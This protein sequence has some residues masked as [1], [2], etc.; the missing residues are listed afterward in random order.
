MNCPRCGAEVPQRFC[1]R[2]G[3]EVAAEPAPR[4]LV[5]C[6]SCG[7]AFSGSFCPYCGA[8]ARP[9]VPAVT[10]C[11]HCGTLFQG[12]YCP[13]CG[14]AAA[15]YPPY[16]EVS[17]HDSMRKMIHVLGSFVWIGVLIVFLLLLVVI[18]GY[19]FWGMSEVIPGIMDQGCPDCTVT[20]FVLVPFPLGLFSFSD[21]GSFFLY[22]L[23]LLVAIAVSLSL[24]VVL[25]G[26]K[27]VSDMVS[28][29]KDGRLKLS[30][31][32]SWAM[33]CQLFC[34]YLFFTAAYLLFLSMFEV[35]ASSPSMV[36]VP[37]WYMLFELA[38]ASVYEEIAT[39]LVFLGV[40]MFLIALGAGVRGRPLLKELFGGSGRMKPY[41]WALIIV[42]AMIFGIAHIPSWDIFKLAPALFAGLIL[43]YL[44]V[45]RGIWAAILFH[46]AVDYYAASVF[47]SVE[48][49]HLGVVIFLA[50]AVVVFI[51]AGFLFFIYYSVKVLN[52]LGSLFRLPRPAPAPAGG[53]RTARG[54]PPQVAS[55]QQFGFVCPKCGF[56]EARYI[57]GRFQCL[58]CGHVQ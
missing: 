13:V 5:A 29:V 18:S 44:Y 20:I 41:T 52:A 4:G 47:V 6:P 31:K 14:Q 15:Y 43:G 30:T 17:L 50:L 19:L 21:P 27:L 42:S 26:K 53:V 24:A 54:V 33:V 3:F 56:Q 16:Q 32:T 8:V 38:N 45:K 22:Y 48:G 10:Q 28:S 9:T 55:P 2:C 57:E 51:V 46:F 39:R 37:L 12:S 25:D 49:G 58:R 40:P 35:D 7:Q 23:A 36:D 11:A 1:P 34:T